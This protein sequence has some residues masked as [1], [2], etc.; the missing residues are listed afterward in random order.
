MYR[1]RADA[2]APAERVLEAEGIHWLQP[3]PDGGIVFERRNGTDFDVG[4]AS[5]RGDDALRMLIEGPANEED[6][7]VSPDGRWLAYES[8]ETGR[9][10]VYVMPFGDDGRG[11]QVSVAGGNNPQWS[12]DG[13]TLF[14]RN[15]QDE[16]E[17]I[18]IG[19]GSGLEVLGR[20]VLFDITGLDGRF[21]PAPGDSLFMAKRGGP[22]SDAR[23]IL[24][25]NWARELAARAEA[26]RDRH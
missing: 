6:P 25:R 3:T 22:R 19:T 15:G 1:V 17:A 4:T 8:D 7:A 13:L 2:S 16:F 5:L 26:V 18:R 9:R 24:V 12:Y 14:Y 11:R 21:H 23:I 10:E 20:S